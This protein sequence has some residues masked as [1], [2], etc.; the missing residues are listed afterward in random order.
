MAYDINPLLLTEAGRIGPDIYNKTLNTSPW[1]KLIKQGA[2][3]D[4]MGTEITVPTYERSLPANALTWSGVTYNTP[5]SLSPGGAGS[6]S[7]DTGN[8][9]E[10]TCLPPF[11]TIGFAQTMRTYGLKHTALESPPICVNDLRFA[12]K[13]QEQL[14]MM[15][16]VLTQNTSYA[17]QDRYRNEYFRNC[18][19]KCVARTGLPENTSLSLD[20]N[21]ISTQMFP[22]QLPTSYLTQGILNTIYMK[23]IRDG[24]GINPMGIVNAR[25]QFSVILSSEASD[26][27]I[28]D[29]GAIQEDFRYGKPNELLAPLG[30]ERSYRG[31]YHLVDDFM[32]RYN[33]TGSAWSRVL[34]YA[35]S[36]ATYGT[37]QEISTAYENA[38]YEVAVV[39]HQ[40]VIESL[41]PKP[42]T[43]PGG[44]TKF[45]P[46]N[47]RGD[48]SWKNIIDKTDNPDGTIG[49]FRGVL[50]SGT[51][52]IRPEW[53]WAILYQ[54]CGDMA[55]TACPTS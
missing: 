15:F 20:P 30:V 7:P 18:G 39:F 23:L 40:D 36:A 22:A 43:S 32:P 55:L 4:E 17:W 33:W 45:N 14:S 10:G 9:G 21:S 3:L 12:F 13:R 54:R 48:W 50:S 47:Y 25:P 53:G 2:W 16:N 1:L 34:P 11:Q 28:R 49:Y 35:G 52:P 26:R 44:N 37:K 19:H 5:D 24:A 41:I 29:N 46:V 27:I 42:I 51:K 31:F 6:Q 8:T 38:Q